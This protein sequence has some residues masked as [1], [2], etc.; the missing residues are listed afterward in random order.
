MLWRSCNKSKWE[1]LSW[2]PALLPL[3][4]PH[5]YPRLTFGLRVRGTPNT[6]S[7]INLTQVLEEWV[8][9]LVVSERRRSCS[10]WVSKECNSWRW[11]SAGQPQ[12]SAHQPRV[13]EAD[14]WT[15]PSP[16]TPDTSPKSPSTENWDIWG[17]LVF[18]LNMFDLYLPDEVRGSQWELTEAFFGSSLVCLPLYLGGKK[19]FLSVNTLKIARSTARCH[20][21][22]N[23]DST[24]QNQIPGKSPSQRK[25]IWS[26][27][28]IKIMKK[29]ELQWR[30]C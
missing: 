13:W 22:W 6:Y 1:W 11:F 18:K 28:Q 14:G 27:N 5:T 9:K 25:S 15:Q 2:F 26:K 7:K 29:T 16:C 24:G 21:N 23:N 20:G 3:K 12:Q 17:L 8:K 4:E 19:A 30:K 10:S